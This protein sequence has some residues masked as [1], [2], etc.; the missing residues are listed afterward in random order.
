M[1]G[2]HWSETAVNQPWRIV[3]LLASAGMAAASGSDQ[4]HGG[5]QAIT[6]VRPDKVSV[7]A[8]T[9]KINYREGGSKAL[10][11]GVLVSDDTVLTAGHCA[12]GSR[13]TYTATI[14]NGGTT[15]F[16]SA[17]VLFPGFQC[18]TSSVPQPG[19]D[20]ALL[21]LVRKTDIPPPPI[22][23][24][25]EAKDQA[26]GTLQIVGFGLTDNGSFG[27]Q[28]EAAVPVQS[29]T[30]VESWAL[31]QGCSAYRE[32]IL[33][34]PGTRP[35]DTCGGDSGGPVFAGP[36]SDWLVGITSRGLSTG[37]FKPACGQ[38]GIYETVARKPVIT[39]LAEHGVPWIKAHAP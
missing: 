5:K 23:T 7:R 36:N 10:C 27:T 32:F 2:R 29:W 39:W 20:L 12:C 8:N 26:T 35:S 17:L 22:A 34:E 28:F 4:V 19:R 37:R 15:L 11:S 21:K 14:R 6:V 1:P 24:I 9:A 13:S 18:S 3:L 16:V 25:W 31:D 33:T 30:C 38:G